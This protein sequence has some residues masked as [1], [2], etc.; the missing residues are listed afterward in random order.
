MRSSEF[1][2]LT[3]GIFVLVG[4]IRFAWSVF[5]AWDVFRLRR[6]FLAS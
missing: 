5:V 3:Q 4:P 1:F 2:C 6:V